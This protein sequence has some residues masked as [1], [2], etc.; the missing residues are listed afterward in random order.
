MLCVE[1]AAGPCAFV[2]FGA[3]GDLAHRKLFASL[4]ELFRRDLMSRR[5]YCIGCGRSVYSDAAFR[6]AVRVSLK[7]ALETAEAETLELFLRQIY[8]VA[9]DYGDAALYEQ[10]CAKMTELDAVYDV[11]GVRIFYL[12]VPPFLYGEIVEK[13]GTLRLSCP[14]ATGRLQDVRLV[15]EKPFGRDLETAKEL[16]RVLGRHFQ[17]SQ[18]YRKIGRASCRGTV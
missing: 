11:E 9:G 5:F 14:A 8:Y 12:S 10:I 1:T 17:E 13:L 3:S 18:I 7:E 4:Y 2:V 6:D 16:D 15:V